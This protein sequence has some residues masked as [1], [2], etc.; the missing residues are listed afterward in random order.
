MTGI[1]AFGLFSKVS[2]FKVRSNDMRSIS[3]N[4]H[5]NNSPSNT[6]SLCNEIKPQENNLHN[7]R[8]HSK[9][10]L[11]Y[12][13]QANTEHTIEHKLSVAVLKNINSMSTIIPA[14]S[15][16]DRV[17]TLNEENSKKTSFTIRFRYTKHT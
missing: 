16:L 5:G 13:K 4:S 8:L 7:I 9:C 12:A 11:T 3:N 1:I 17:G 6:L 15:V 10:L 14:M 2:S